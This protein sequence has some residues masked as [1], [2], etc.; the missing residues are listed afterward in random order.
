M[1]T[2]ATALEPGAPLFN[3]RAESLRRRIVK[4]WGFRMYLL[5]RLPLAAAAGL[6][7]LRLDEE[8]CRVRLPGGWRTRNPFGSTYFA[9]QAMAAEMSTGAPAM[10]LVEGAPASVA[11]ILR[12]IK[13]VFSKRIEGPSTFT[14][15][16]VPALQAAIL[17]AAA[18]SEPVLF[19]AHATGHDSSGAPCAAF[20]VTW[21]FKRRG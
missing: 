1:T 11:L 6:R 5:G 13:C 7:V 9:A 8:G 16:A 10:V 2:T 21:S 12:E 18:T 14:F 17:R 19:V 15:A 4:P 20:E 3:E